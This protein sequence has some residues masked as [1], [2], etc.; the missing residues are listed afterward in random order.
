MKITIA[1]ASPRFPY[2]AFR[3]ESDIRYHHGNIRFSSRALKVKKIGLLAISVLAILMSVASPSF[4]HSIGARHLVGIIQYVNAHAREAELLPPDKAKPLRFKWD[5]Q[6]R[7]VAN[8]QL[9]DA[10]ILSSGVRV[11]VVYIQPFFGS[12]YVTKVTLL[13]PQPLSHK[14][15]G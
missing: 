14:G 5:K 15:W 3:I 11:E 2:S 7:F 12:P 6:T 4:A 8:Q 1:S 10:V 13:Q 9:V